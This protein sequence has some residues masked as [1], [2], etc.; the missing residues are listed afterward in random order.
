MREEPQ[1]T[2]P[3]VA[4]VSAITG[5]GPAGVSWPGEE[6]LLEAQA[7]R[8]RHGLWRLLAAS[9]LPLLK[10]RAFAFSTHYTISP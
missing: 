6:K 5:A 3:I 9:P 4:A 2:T 7:P 8:S 1:I 10:R